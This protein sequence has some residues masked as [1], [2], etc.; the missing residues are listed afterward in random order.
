MP[1]E[2]WRPIPEYRLLGVP[3]GYEASGLGR[4]RSVPRTLR[5]GRAAGGV[6]LEPQRDKDGYLTVKL[7]RKRVRVNVA[8]Q[9]AFAGPPE[10]RHLD[11]NR[12]NNRPG[13]LA[14][15]SRTENEQDKRRKGKQVG[16]ETGCSRPFPV[17]TTP[18]TGVTDAG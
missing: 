12:E 11:G 10:V 6:L 3:R 5:D 17:G 9:L 4:V 1:D 2:E 14:W 16:T 7:G 15:G 8:V 18:V 13:N